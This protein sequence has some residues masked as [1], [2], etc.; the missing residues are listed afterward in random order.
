MSQ[1]R[2]AH[3]AR[4]GFT[5]VELLVVIGIIA[6]LISV[7]MPALRRAR[8]QA[9]KVNCQSQLRQIT[10]ALRIYSNQYNGWLPGTH[11]ICKQG[12]LTPAGAQTPVDTGLLWIA[13]C[14]REK[15]VWNCPIDPREKGTYQY[16]YT[17]NGRMITKPGWEE[18]PW[19]VYGQGLMDENRVPKPE[20]RKITSFRKPA[21]C[22]VYGEEN[23]HGARVGPYVINDAYY[24]FDDVSDDRHMG[25]SCVGYLDGHCGEMPPKIKLFAS[26]EWGY[27]R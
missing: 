2:R 1:R 19:P 24:I 7:L 25:K 11:S 10:T 5:L 3:G 6:I 20:Y 12:T 16:S 21:E 26:T 8:N 14:L 13:N 18:H 4:G 15:D 17:Y 27:C 22:L 23:V 9:A